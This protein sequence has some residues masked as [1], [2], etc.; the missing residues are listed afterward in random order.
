M[1]L[2][3]FPLN[4]PFCAVAKSQNWH[5]YGLSPVC[6]RWCRFRSPT[7]AVWKL[8]SRQAYGFSPVC[9]IRCNLQ[10]KANDTIIIT[11]HISFLCGIHRLSK[12]S[13][14]I[15]CHQ[16]K[17]AWPAARVVTI[18]TAVF[19]FT[20]CRH[21]GGCVSRAGH[22]WR[23]G[24]RW[25]RGCR[26]PVAAAWRWR[27]S[28]ASVSAGHCFGRGAARP[29]K[30]CILLQTSADIVA[31][32]EVDRTG[33][34]RA[35]V[36]TNSCSAHGRSTAKEDWVTRDARRWWRA[37]CVGTR[38]NSRRNGI[39]DG[40]RLARRNSSAACGIRCQRAEPR[41]R[42]T[43]SDISDCGRRHCRRW[44]SAASGQIGCISVFCKCVKS[45]ESR[46]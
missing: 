13:I 44:D 5:A 32:R 23:W 8:H 34:Q 18:V 10:S 7:H 29:R 12:F 14:K 3:S 22:A 28:T 17:M 16:P 19:L 21:R 4:L 15:P 46:K 27:I 2:S 42:K 41:K 40:I 35:V 38:W 26:A 33:Y 11:F 25:R 1:K 9:R 39:S 45:I 30:L 37:H 20:I 43:S 31:Y 36:W 24:R 6:T